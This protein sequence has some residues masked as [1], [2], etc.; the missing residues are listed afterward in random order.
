[1]AQGEPELRSFG[2]RGRPRAQGREGDRATGCPERLPPHAPERMDRAGRAL[3]RYRRLGRVQWSGGSRDATRPPVLRWPRPLDHH[4]RH[5][6]RL[7]LPARAGRW[8]LALG[9]ALL[10]ARG[11][12]EEARRARLRAL[13]TRGPG[14]ASSRRHPATSSTTAR[15]SS[16][17]SP[18][19]PCSRSGRSPTTPGTRPTSR[20]ASR[21]RAPP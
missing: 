7:G 12:P 3:D 19:P 16:A 10:R 20:C 1:M 11:E 21:T 17:S 18:M 9:V 5:G 2:E 8:P 15:S 4:R 13:R 14:R 6:S